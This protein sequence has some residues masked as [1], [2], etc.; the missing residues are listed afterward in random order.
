MRGALVEARV[1]D[2]MHNPDAADRAMRRAR[3]LAG[4]RAF[5]DPRA[6]QAMIRP[7]ETPQS[8]HFKGG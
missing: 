7:G 5:D 2:A 3:A 4:E 6:S 8:G 1:Y